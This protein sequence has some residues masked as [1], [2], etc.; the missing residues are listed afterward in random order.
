MKKLYWIPN[1]IV[2][3][4]HLWDHQNW[5]E[6]GFIYSWIGKHLTLSWRSFMMGPYH[7]E[8]SSLICLEN[9]WTGSYMICHETIRDVIRAEC[10]R[11]TK[12]HQY[13]FSVSLK[14]GAYYITGQ[15]GEFI[16][17][18]YVILLYAF[19]A[20][21]F[22]LFLVKFVFLL[23]SFLFW[24]SIKFPQQ[25]INQSETWIGGFQLSV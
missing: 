23:F 5:L 4:A 20:F 3:P 10:A 18:C 1:T 2:T 12:W 21:F 19:L 13:I 6:N 8:S 24:W 25:N 9:R 7:I 11:P 14:F 22:L 16:K 17:K 15:W